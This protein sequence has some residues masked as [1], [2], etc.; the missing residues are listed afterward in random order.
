[1]R[2]LPQ[3]HRRKHFPWNGRPPD[4]SSPPAEVSPA[5]SRRLLNAAGCLLLERYVPISQ[6]AQ[7]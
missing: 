1:M 3:L 6:V 7:V 4:C 5:Y 2:N